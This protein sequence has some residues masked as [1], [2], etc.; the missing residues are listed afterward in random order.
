MGSIENKK[1]EGPSHRTQ[2]TGV[3]GG[4]CSG[5][6]IAAIIPTFNRRER[7]LQAIQ[8]VLDQTLPATEIIV[9]DDGSTDGSADSIR[10]QFPNI[11]LIEQANRGVSAARNV[12]ISAAS[13]QWLAFLDSDDQWYP[14]KLGSQMQALRQSDRYRI[15]HCDEHWIRNGKRVNPMQKHQK[16]GGDIF[17]YCLPLCAI[18]PSAVIIHHSV[19]DEFGVFDETLPACEDYDLWLRITQAEKVCFVD[20]ALLQKTGG[21]SD[22]LSRRY[23]AMDKFRLYSLAKVLRGNQLSQQQTK[24]ALST[25]KKK[26]SIYTEGAVKRG[27]N[28]EVQRL[29]SLYKDLLS[30]PY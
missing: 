1:N 24:L 22:Q 29:T 2:P 30:H 9:V 16:Y 21:H 18:S 20:K 7:V 11:T 3:R 10:E 25:F 15:C 26:F 6:T 13:S 4:L 5:D 19:F 8:S 23:S 14:E 27:R 17:E 28:G 12:A